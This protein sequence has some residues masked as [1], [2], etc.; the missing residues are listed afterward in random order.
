[1][2]WCM[3]VPGLL[4]GGH[5]R[6]CLKPAGKLSRAASSSR[7]FPTPLLAPSFPRPLPHEVAAQARGVDSDAAPEIL[8]SSLPESRSGRISPPLSRWRSD[9]SPN[10]TSVGVGRSR[11][12]ISSTTTCAGL[13]IAYWGRTDDQLI[14]K[15]ATYAATR[16][17]L[18]RR[19]FKSTLSVSKLAGVHR[20]RHNKCDTSIHS[21]IHRRPS[22][23]SRVRRSRLR[24]S[25]RLRQRALAVNAEKAADRSS[26]SRRR[27]VDPRR[28]GG[29]EVVNNKTFG[30]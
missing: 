13:S 22:T 23:S 7:R 26:Q 19:C 25:Q 29:H 5:D 21:S 14:S 17:V 1:M 27:G 3:V 15:A 2:T 30:Q 24:R 16:C 28:Y 10:D 8:F 6:R 18:A 4:S 12:R 9:S 20:S 11:Q